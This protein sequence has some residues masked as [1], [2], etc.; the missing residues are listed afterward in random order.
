MAITLGNKRLLLLSSTLT[1]LT[2]QKRNEGPPFSLKNFGSKELF[3]QADFTLIIL[4]AK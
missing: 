1:L 2:T 3:M 4:K